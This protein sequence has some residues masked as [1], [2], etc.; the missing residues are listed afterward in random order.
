MTPE[1]RLKH[2]F[3]RAYQ[4]LFV[5]ASGN[6]GPVNKFER[7]NATGVQFSVPVRGCSE[8]YRPRSRG[9]P[10]VCRWVQE[11]ENRLESVY[12]GNA[13]CRASKGMVGDAV[14]HGC[15]HRF[16]KRLA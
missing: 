16:G 14:W 8:L 12:E 11:A 5:F 9:Y 1:E 13:N 7:K 2:E 6:S 10:I 3:L 15:H 4:V